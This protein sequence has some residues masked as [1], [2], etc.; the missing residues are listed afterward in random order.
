MPRAA[1][2]GAVRLLGVEE[3]SVATVRHDGEE[4]QLSQGESDLQRSVASYC[5]QQLEQA[6]RSHLVVDKFGLDIAIW[7]FGADVT[8]AKFVELKVFAGARQGG[9]GFGNGRGEGPQ[10]DLLI[11]DDAHLVL[12]DPS[13]RWI[14]ADATRPHGSNRF[15]FVTSLEAKNAAMGTVARGKQ[16]NLNIAR[17]MRKPCAWPDLCAQLAE[18]ILQ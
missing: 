11:Q 14:V 2:L 12:L 15:S 3:H 5:R 10:V 6:R 1:Q 16:N 9:V 13:I 4:P 8:V 7:V 17:L 18:F